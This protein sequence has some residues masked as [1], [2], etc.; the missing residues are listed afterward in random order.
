MR[1]GIS[2]R[3]AS[4]PALVPAKYRQLELKVKNRWEIFMRIVLADLKG[5]NGFV[6]K[7]TV[8]GGFGLRFKGWS[9]TTRWI[10][11]A[12]NLF[13]NVPSVHAA[14]IAAILEREGHEVVY[15]NDAYMEG[16]VALVLSS[17]VDYR[18]ETAWADTARRQF[19]MK[20]GFFGA[21]ATHAK[22]LLEGH[23]DFIIKGEPEQAALR[24]ARGEKLEGLVESPAIA[25]LDGLPFP[26]WHL[27]QSGHGRH[28]VGRSLL[29][30]LWSKRSAF[31]ILSSRS[32]PEFC[33]YCPHRTT[34][35][36]RS[37]SPE[38]VLAEIENLCKRYGN[39]YLIFRDP[40]FSVERERSV[41]IARGI[42]ER[43]LPVRFECET[44]LDSLDTDLLDVFY[45]AGLRTITFGVESL[46]PSTLKRVGRRPIPPEHQRKMVDY[47]RQKGISTEG[48]Y[49]FGFLEDTADSLR[50][51]IQYSIDLNT[52]AAMFKLLTPYPGTPLRKR[53]EPLITETDPEKFDGYTPTFTHPNLKHNEL[54]FLLGS[55]Y[56]RF[57]CR[58]SW[59]T[60]YMGIHSPNAEWL[61]NFDEMAR[62]KQMQN[63]NVFLSSQ[64]RSEISQ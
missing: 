28:A 11:R 15:T 54:R 41:A 30:S 23:G 58:P 53:M 57:Y 5:S 64:A 18:H 46:E 2:S 45:D 48:F 31:P 21:V 36:Y 22:H 14:Y 35:S 40:L 12:R 10:E 25:D 17:L 8:V 47:C 24:L 13:Q 60:T 55:A 9:F 43:Q 49:V 16:D 33:T 7:D 50:A 19:G 59:L 3:A 52:T 32:C 20:V 1:R 4:Q 42:T 61:R 39:T 6:N 63:E 37:R 51:T 38:N 44:R 34:A 27:L 62:M 29:P 26:A 56:N